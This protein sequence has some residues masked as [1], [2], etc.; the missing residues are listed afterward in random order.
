MSSRYERMLEAIANGEQITEEPICR[1]EVFLKALANKEGTSNLP[2]PICREEEFY[3][4]IIAGEQITEEPIC[5]REEYLK[6][7]ANGES[8]PES[9]GLNCKEEKLL[10]NVCTSGAGGGGSGGGGYTSV[11]Y[12][13]NGIFYIR[14]AYSA[15][16]A[17]ALIL[18]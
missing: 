8:L 3:R 14:D 16:L 12:V 18:R 1:R 11:N 15:T 7:M 13:S 4:A 10:R 2:E 5:K 17:D 6:A 9:S